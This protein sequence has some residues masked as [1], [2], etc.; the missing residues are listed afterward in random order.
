MKILDGKKTAG[1]IYQQ[2]SKG[3]EN[4]KGAIGRS[5]RLDM[6]LVGENFA[7]AK[8]IKM[9]KKRAAEVGIESV[10][11]ELPED[12]S[13]REL[14]AKIE[15]LNKYDGVDGF[16]VQ[17]PLPDHFDSREVLSH[18]DPSKDVDG[19]TAMNL[20]RLYQG[21]E[22]AFASATPQGVLLLLE[23]YKIDLT[24]KNVVIIGRSG[25]VGLPLSALMTSA[26]ATVTVAHSKSVDL[27]KICKTADILVSATGKPKLVDEKFVKEGAIVID[28]GI[29]LDKYGS[30]CGDVD[31]ESVKDIV[32][33]ISPVP[34]GVGPMTIAA[35][36]WNCYRKW[37]SAA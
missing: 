35:L 10:I 27:A 23:E 4:S 31:F 30:L 17:L 15:E 11:H 26:D 29:N 12:I 28:V 18:I 16:M 37:G 2:I 25:V 19:L 24:G 8:Y 3:I 21:D 6:I 14:I 9:K 13:Q 33:Y 36:M 34:G 5:P 22:R 7:S 20:G 32:S 1:K